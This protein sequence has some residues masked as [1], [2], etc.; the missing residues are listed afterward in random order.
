M[1]LDAAVLFLFVTG[2]S[3]A[4]GASVALLDVNVVP[5]DAERVLAHQTVVVT[6]GV[7]VRVGPF[8]SVSPP[9]DAV[10]I[11]GRGKFLLPGLV[12]FH[13]HLQCPDELLTYLAHGVTSVVNL[14]GAPR[15]LGWRAL[16]GRPD[17]AGARLFTAGPTLDGFPPTTTKFVALATPE[18]GRAAV[19]AQKAAGYDLVKVYARLSLDVLEAM[20]AEGRLRRIAVVGHVPRAVG[21]VKA[22]RAGETMIA[23]A[24]EF[25]RDLF[26]P[27]THSFDASRIPGLVAVARAT[28]VAVTP[29]LSAIQ[30]MLD[31]VDDLPALLARPE[32]R[33][34]TPAAYDELKSSNNRYTNRPN[35]TDFRGRVTQQLAVEK[36]LVK[37]LSDAGV[38]LLLGTDAST[39]GLPGF[40]DGEEIR[41]LL[42]AGLTPFETL[43]AATRTAGELLGRWTSLA[44]PIGVVAEGAAADLLLV[45]KNPLEDP[46]SAVRPDGVVRGGRWFSRSDLVRLQAKASARYPEQK[47]FVDRFDD[48]VHA[49]KTAEAVALF[50][51]E[52]PGFEGAIPLKFDVL[53]AQGRDLIGKDARAARPLVDLAAR[54]YP[55]EVSL[56][57]NLGEE[58]RLAGDPDGARRAYE[59]A[60]ALCPQDEIAK[61]GRAALAGE[62]GPRP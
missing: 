11:D 3:E 12:D 44:A 49:G 16:A 20:T 48:L 45:S 47:A 13:V 40:S 15:F 51:K 6:D 61:R 59:E 10:R 1:R 14:N 30:F 8:A 36:K 4:A 5:M 25:L 41:L 52:R 54:L 28:G 32:M 55:D 26:D 18:A 58:R 38:P 21:S 50:E 17:F 35:L 46:S 43:R 19:A 42:E 24:E 34:V 33:D 31:Q 62:P 27:G 53:Y 29:N 56:R 60:L 7:I 39:V 9:A 37:A 2:A 23:H 57:D 22:M